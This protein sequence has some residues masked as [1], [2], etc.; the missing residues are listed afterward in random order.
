MPSDKADITL[1]RGESDMP[2]FLA[3]FNLSPYE[4]EIKLKVTYFLSLHFN[5]KSEI[6]STTYTLRGSSEPVYHTYTSKLTSNP[7]FNRPININPTKTQRAVVKLI[8]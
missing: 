1:D 7:I 6:Q 5:R 2:I 8:Y 4:I 3:S